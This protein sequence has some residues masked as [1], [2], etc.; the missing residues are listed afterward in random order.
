MGCGFGSGSGSG[1]QTFQGVQ[2]CCLFGLLGLAFEFFDE[3]LDVTSAA[4]VFHAVEFAGGCEGAVVGVEG[5]VLD[6]RGVP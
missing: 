1:L 6:A 5:D 3:A 2:G 4:S